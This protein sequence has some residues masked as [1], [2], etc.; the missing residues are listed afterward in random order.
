MRRLICAFVVRIG[1]KQVFSWRGSIMNE[2]W[3]FQVLL[4]ILLLCAFY[5]K[6]KTLDTWKND[7]NYS[8][9]W[10]IWI[11]H[12]VMCIND[13]DGMANSVN[14][15][16]TVPKS[17][18]K[19]CCTYCQSDNC[20]YWMV[21]FSAL[22]WFYLFTTTL[23]VTFYKPDNNVI[24][25]HLFTFYK[26]DNVSISSHLFRQQ[27]LIILDRNI[28]SFFNQYYYYILEK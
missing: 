20:L 15:D 18:W 28:C 9:I 27:S 24:S 22:V 6:T 26:P 14:P 2:S 5:R 23:C 1:Q 4:I 11:F 16:Q 10:L 7:C 25:S 17:G 8:K 13:V 19:T 21:C 12:R 3:T